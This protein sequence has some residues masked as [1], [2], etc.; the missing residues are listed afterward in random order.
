M[1]L[2]IIISIAT[3]VCVTALVAAVAFMLRGDRPAPSKTGWRC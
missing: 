2:Y 1:S 3:F